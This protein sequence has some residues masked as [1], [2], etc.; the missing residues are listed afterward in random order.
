MAQLN[1][2]IVTGRASFL[3]EIKGKIDWTNINNKPSSFTPASHTHGNIQNGGT[4]TTDVTIAN[5]DKLVV[6]DNSD[7]SK[8]ARMSISFDGS[9]TTQCLTKKGTWETFGT[10][11]LTLGTSSTTALKGDTKYA[12]ASTT[13]RLRQCRRK[14]LGQ[15][16]PTRCSFTT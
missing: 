14:M 7:N 3:N 5:G 4:L 12:G 16:P 10:S 1:D 11:N 8:I 2:L 6:T 15:K 9:T 13:L